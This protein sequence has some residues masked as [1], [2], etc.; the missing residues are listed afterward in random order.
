MHI[1]FSTIVKLR[2]LCDKKRII[3]RTRH[4]ISVKLEKVSMTG[5]AHQIPI[6]EITRIFNKT[7]IERRVL[8][9]GKFR[10]I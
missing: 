4:S 8:K 1:N 10:N 6:N 3:K 9:K 2:I 5:M 7:S